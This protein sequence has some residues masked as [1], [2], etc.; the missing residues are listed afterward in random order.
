MDVFVSMSPGA[1]G[2]TLRISAAVTIALFLVCGTAA[3][4]TSANDLRDRLKEG[5]KVDVTD[6]QGRELRG[7]IVNLTADSLT[8]TRGADRQL[9]PYAQ[10]VKIDRVDDLRNGALVGLGV[11]LGLFALDAVVSSENGITLNPAGYLV[12]GALYGAA[13]AGAGVGIDALIGGNR[14]IYQ[15]GGSTRISLVPSIGRDRIGAAIGISW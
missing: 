8:L 13:G 5:Q 12:I 15:R 10:I 9:V 3:G 1:G 7:R 2:A 11:G 6:E 14:N 4:Q